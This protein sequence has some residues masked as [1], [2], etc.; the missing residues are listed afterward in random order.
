M[1]PQED[2]EHLRKRIDQ[3]L[4][5][6]TAI[7]PDLAS[8]TFQVNTI[9]EQDWTAQWRRFFRP[10]QVTPHLMIWPAWEPMPDSVST[11]VIRIDPGPAFGTGQHAT[12]RLCLAAMEKIPL[13]PSGSMLDVGT[14]SGILAI[15]GALLGAGHILAIDIDPEAVRWA[16][17]N[18]RLNDLAGAIE[19]SDQPLEALSDA[20]TLVTANLILE[21]ILRTL[22]HLSR[23]TQPGGW[24]ILSGIL[25]D[26]VEMVADALAAYPFDQWEFSHQGEWACAVVRKGGSRP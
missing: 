4:K 21:E 24:L 18:I 10:E 2:P 5:D 22:K 17:E 19:I 25:G 1:P 6:L 15:Y 9:A 11:R 26:Q 7:F 23:L 13:R 3:F 12:T 16:S 20:F 14:G 8:P